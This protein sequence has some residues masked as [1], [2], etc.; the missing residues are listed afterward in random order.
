MP[1][2]RLLLAAAAA[3]L[4][5]SY[6]LAALRSD[7]AAPDRPVAVMDA[8]VVTD[9][10]PAPDLVD[11]PR[12]VD[13]G[14]SRPPRV[15]TCGQPHA[16][17]NAQRDS[18]MIPE[19]APFLTGVLNTAGGV[20]NL[21]I[22]GTVPPGCGSQDFRQPA[23]APPLRILR[24]Q[25][26]AGPRVT[27]STNTGACGSGDVRVMAFSSC[28][29]A[30]A[31]SMPIGCN[32]DDNFRL[33][34]TCATASNEG[35]CSPFQSS[36]T[37]GNLIA[38]DVIWFGVH[39]F[40]ASATNAG[41]G[42][43]RAWIG[44]NALT[45][46]ALPVDAPFVSNR[47]TCQSETPRVVRTVRWP[48]SADYGTAMPTAFLLAQDQTGVLGVRD[49]PGLASVLGVSARFTIA[50]VLRDPAEECLDDPSAILDLVIG[51]QAEGWV[52]ASSQF[53]ANSARAPLT[54]S[55]PY[56]PVS[57]AAGAAM[58]VTPARGTNR[59]NFELRLRR[60]LPDKKC[61][62]LNL[63]LSTTSQNNVVLYGN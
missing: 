36:V 58:G 20:E 23:A 49:V 37:V 41:T 35:V 1:R 12:P 44:E 24:Y 29:T 25:V 32:D 54:V 14:P 15:G 8:P 13:T 19:G 31:R 59:Y 38:G 53:I 55:F 18:Q 10:G 16:N 9:R 50:S 26:Q 51:N 42:P 60:S 5:C 4:G 45:P 63:D 2:A 62:R 30:Q 46:V 43:F 52:V 27:L 7:A 61:V 40:Q 47:C 28:D 22:P 17:L 56:T 34:P 21:S 48:E 11:A 33:C 3:G 6:D 39:T 57:R